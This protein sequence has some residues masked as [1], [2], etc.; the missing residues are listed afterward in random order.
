MTRRAW[1]ARDAHFEGVKERLA[2]SA[3]AEIKTVRAGCNSQNREACEQDVKKLT[4]ARD[5]ALADL[6]NALNWIEAT[7]RSR[8][9]G[10]TVYVG[11][12]P[13]DVRAARALG[14]PFIGV[15][16]QSTGVLR[17]AGVR[18]VIG[19]YRDFAVFQSALCDAIVP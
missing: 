18:H 5:K 10:R 19:G 3:D 7:R 2:K 8:A 14:M 11:D 17:H 13:W 6:D 1:A 9:A 16:A 4:E 12:G 15:D